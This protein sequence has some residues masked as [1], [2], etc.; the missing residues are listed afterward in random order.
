MPLSRVV[1]NLDP[2]STRFDVVIID[3]ASQMDVLGLV[4]MAMAR[5]V[6]VVGDH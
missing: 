5:G 2:A 6:V 4:A 1:E 3:E